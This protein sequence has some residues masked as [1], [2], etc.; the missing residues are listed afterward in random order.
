MQI[1]EPHVFATIEKNQIDHRFYSLR[2]FMLLL[3]QEFNMLDTIR[4]W[5]TLLSD[6]SKFDF[7]NFVS[8]AL[9]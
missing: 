6:P 1:M 7:T 8:L 4:L 9:V 2:W 5:D 3:C